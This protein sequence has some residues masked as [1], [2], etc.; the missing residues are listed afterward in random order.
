MHKYVRKTSSVLSLFQELLECTADAEMEW[1]LFKGD[2]AS[3]V[4]QV[5]GWTWITVVDN[6]KK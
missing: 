6:D 4:A 3:S 1:K 5:C 2:A